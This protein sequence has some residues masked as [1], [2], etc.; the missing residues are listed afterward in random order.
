MERFKPSSHDDEVSS[1]EFVEDGFDG[2]AE[3]V[4]AA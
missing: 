1:H 3:G 4:F 2:A